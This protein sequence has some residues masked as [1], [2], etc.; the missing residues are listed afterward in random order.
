MNSSEQVQQNL[1]GFDPAINSTHDQ[2]RF[3]ADVW[4]DWQTLLKTLRS[5]RHC[6]GLIGIQ[7]TFLHLNQVQET[8]FA[9]QVIAKEAALKINHISED[10][11]IKE[12]KP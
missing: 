1:P 12:S 2:A 10:F 6:S 9:A 4:N 5:G 11:A 3:L 8:F 7:Q